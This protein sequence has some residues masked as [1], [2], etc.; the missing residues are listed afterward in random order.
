[1]RH[2]VEV[3]SLKGHL[4]K[5]K[6][7]AIV[8]GGYIGVEMA[9]VLLNMGK[10]VLLFEIFDQ[11]L[12]GALDKDVAA[13]VSEEMKNRGVELH[14][15]EGVVEFRGAEHVEKVVTERGSIE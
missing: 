3:P 15:G 7:V 1:M 4:E 5:A 9:E 10:R 6:T 8:G 12:P 2:P 13:I 11:V 14:L